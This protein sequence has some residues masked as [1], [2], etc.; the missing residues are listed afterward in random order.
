MMVVRFF[1]FA[2]FSAVPLWSTL[3]LFSSLLFVIP[4]PLEKAFAIQ[5]PVVFTSLAALDIHFPHIL[6]AEF[7][8]GYYYLCPN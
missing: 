8:L 7:T 3:L 1:F 6:E 4:K 2:P 5:R